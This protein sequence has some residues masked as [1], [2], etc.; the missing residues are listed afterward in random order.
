MAYIEVLFSL[1]D[2][3]DQQEI[4]TA[5]LAE[6]GFESFFWKTKLSSGLLP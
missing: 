6:I 2:N 3:T 4:L 1:T 5:E